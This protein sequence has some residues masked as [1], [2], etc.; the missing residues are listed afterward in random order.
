M[1]DLF[2]DSSAA[3]AALIIIVLPLLIIGSGEVE[4]RLRQTRL[5]LPASCRD[6]PRLGRSVS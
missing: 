6:A 2:P 3:W 1:S 5:P 4:E